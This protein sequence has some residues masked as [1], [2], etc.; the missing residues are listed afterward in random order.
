MPAPSDT[1]A[2][3][4]LQGYTRAGGTWELVL[5]STRPDEHSQG[6]TVITDVDPYVVD[7]DSSTWAAADD[8]S[9]SVWMSATSVDLGV[10]AGA[11]D[12][13]A[14]A[15]ALRDPGTL[16]HLHS[17]LLAGAGIRIGVGGEV[18]IPGNQVR[19]HIP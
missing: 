2:A 18:N 11:S 16:E 14:V 3:E 9:R 19:L 13:V 15:W 6:G 5:L 8:V 1:A 7:R 4:I 17:S 12:V 10:Y